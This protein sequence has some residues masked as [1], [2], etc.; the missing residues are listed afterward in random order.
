MIKVYDETNEVAVQTE[1]VSVVEDVAK[2]ISNVEI[3]KLIHHSDIVIRD[4][5][6]IRKDL[7]L[8]NGDCVRR[9]F[10]S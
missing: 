6:W 3:V 4:S 2:N 9:W 5:L 10:R 7:I 1:V 8:R